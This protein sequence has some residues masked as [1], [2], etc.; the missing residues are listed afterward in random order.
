MVSAI[1]ESLGSEDLPLR[2]PDGS[3][4]Q[5]ITST[6]ERSTHPDVGAAMRQMHRLDW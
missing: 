3:D 4:A 6:R 2:V 5:L 1:G